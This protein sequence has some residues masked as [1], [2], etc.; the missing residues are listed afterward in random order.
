MA[1]HRRKWRPSL[2]NAHRKTSQHST[3]LARPNR[4]NVPEAI[5]TAVREVGRTTG[6]EA[7][8][9]VELQRTGDGGWLIVVET[10]SPTGVSGVKPEQYVIRLSS[11]GSILSYE[12]VGHDSPSRSAEAPRSALPVD[13][14]LRAE[15]DTDIAIS[16]RRINVVNLRLRGSIRPLR[17]RGKR[18]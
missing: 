7:S 12:L 13:L 3:E 18:S 8:K 1:K 17:N 2:K 15:L 9:V 14:G 4:S 11:E 6:H 10:F 16:F 5:S